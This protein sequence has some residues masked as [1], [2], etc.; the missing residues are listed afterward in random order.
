VVPIG[1]DDPRRRGALVRGLG[2]SS[3]LAGRRVQSAPKL[4]E[5]LARQL[6]TADPQ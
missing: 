6:A 1:R 3:R 5:T 2:E 4:R